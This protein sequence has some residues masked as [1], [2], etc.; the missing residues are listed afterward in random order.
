MGPCRVTP[1][2]PRGICGCDVHGIVARN[3]PGEEA[4]VAEGLAVLHESSLGHLMGQIIDVLA[5][6]LGTPKPIDTTANLGVMEKDMVNI[7]VHGHDPSLSEMIVFYAQDWS[8][9]PGT[10]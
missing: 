7:V 6:G 1:K 3:S 8:R 5:L 9:R 10:S 2:A 4:G